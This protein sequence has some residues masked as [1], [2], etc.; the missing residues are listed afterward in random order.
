MKTFILC[1]LCAR[2]AVCAET[3]S[4]AD[5]LANARKQWGVDAVV[6]IEW[7]DLNSCVVAGDQHPAMSIT[8]WRNT[9]ITYS[10]GA[11]DVVSRASTIAVN[12]S[13]DWTKQPLDKVILHEYGHVLGIEHSSDRKSIMYWIVY[14]DKPQT[15]TGHDRESV[16]VLLSKFPAAAAAR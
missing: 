10:D 4:L 14:P 16:R 12:S 11:P 8:E 1:F 13:C 3:G 7:R 2:A 5:A 9:T 15:I 6:N